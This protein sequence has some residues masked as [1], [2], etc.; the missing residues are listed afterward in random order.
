RLAGNSR[1]HCSKQ[2]RNWTRRY[3]SMSW[4]GWSRQNCCTKEGYHHRQRIPL[5][6]RSFRIL[7]TRHYYEVQ[8]STTI[9]EL[10]RYSKPSVLRPLRHSPNCWHITI[11]RQVW[12]RR[13]CTIGITLVKVP[14]NVQPMWKLSVTCVQGLSCSRHYQRHQSVP[15]VK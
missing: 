2:F 1:M 4:V 8:D 15:D 9:S 5:S 6:M 12:Q 11:P 13:R 10:L 14:S 7:P 3:Y